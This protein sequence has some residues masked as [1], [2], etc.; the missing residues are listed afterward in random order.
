MNED[1]GSTVMVGADSLKQSKITFG[2]DNE[3]MIRSTLESTLSRGAVSAVC[4]DGPG[5]GDYR[6]GYGLIMG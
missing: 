3:V 6:F 5:Q 2:V 4:R 1:G